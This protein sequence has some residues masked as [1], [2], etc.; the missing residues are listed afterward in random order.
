MAID[1]QI[2]QAV[3]TAVKQ[4]KQADSLADKIIAWINAINSGNEDINDPSASS[5][6]LDLIY[7]ETSNKF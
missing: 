1:P 6:H 4:A 5:R 3:R 2:E 7:E